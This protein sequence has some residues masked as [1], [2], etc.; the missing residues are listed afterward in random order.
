MAYPFGQYIITAIDNP[1][2]TRPDS[3]ERRPSVCSETENLRIAPFQTGFGPV[4]A[5]AF[6]VSRLRGGRY[7]CGLVQQP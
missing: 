7:A 1:S 6:Q 5:S 4:A 3:Q 2:L